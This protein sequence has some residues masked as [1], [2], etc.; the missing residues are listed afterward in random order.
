M[1]VDH[2]AQKAAPSE[3]SPL[4]PFPSHS[5]ERSDSTVA[6]RNRLVAAQ[7]ST[8]ADP[9]QIDEELKKRVFWALPALA[10]GIFLAAADQTIVVSSYGKIG[11]EMEALNNT[12]W[13]ATAY[14]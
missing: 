9:D 1:S 5:A 13:I 11:S 6:S 14:L 4:L 3:T 7:Q 8:E 12:S 2:G 10:I